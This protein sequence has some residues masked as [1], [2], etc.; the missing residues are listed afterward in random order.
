MSDPKPC[1]KCGHFLA[2]YGQTRCSGCERTR[3]EELIHVLA[4]GAIVLVAIAIMACAVL[5]S[6][7]LDDPDPMPVPPH[8]GQ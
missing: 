4:I 2:V 1:A 7:P 8:A 6:G 5:T 3:E